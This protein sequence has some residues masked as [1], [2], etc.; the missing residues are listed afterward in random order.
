MRGDPS[1]HD[2]YYARYPRGFGGMVEKSKKKLFC[3]AKFGKNQAFLGD[4]SLNPNRARSAT[5]DLRAAQATPPPRAACDVVFDS[6]CNHSARDRR[7]DG[8]GVVRAAQLGLPSF[9]PPT[10]GRSARTAIVFDA[11]VIPI[12]CLDRHCLGFALGL[13]LQSLGNRAEPNFT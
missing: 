11:A 12:R 8:A 3:D 6:A 7:R 4:R 10:L 9:S 1:A 13:R 2:D 5:N